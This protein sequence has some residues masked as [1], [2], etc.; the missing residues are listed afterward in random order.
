MHLPKFARQARH[1]TTDINLY[2]TTISCFLFLSFVIVMRLIGGLYLPALSH[3]SLS[4]GCR[5]GVSSLETL[6][7]KINVDISTVIT[8]FPSIS[9]VI[10]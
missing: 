7:G 6:C 4:F 2:T 3:Y 1:V 8:H 5:T 9:H 10:S